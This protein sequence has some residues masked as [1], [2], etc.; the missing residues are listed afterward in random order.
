MSFRHAQRRKG[1]TALVVAG[2]MV[3]TAILAGSLATADSLAYAIR[4]SAFKAL[5][6]ADIFVQ[7]PG[8]LFFPS[9]VYDALRADPNVSGSV[10][11]L[12]PEVLEQT[13]ISLPRTHLHAAAVTVVGFDATADAPFGSFV[14]QNGT[15]TTGAEL[16]PTDVYLD[17]AT[18]STLDAQPGD[19]LRL[20]YGAAPQPVLPEILNFSGTL[21]AAAGPGG[22]SPVPGLP[23]LGPAGYTHSP[24]DKYQFGFATKPDLDFILVVARPLT[25]NPPELDLELRSPSGKDYLNSTGSPSHPILPAILLVNS[26]EQGNWTLLVNSKA[27]TNAPFVATV[28]PFYKIYDLAEFANFTRA[29]G[30]RAQNFSQQFGGENAGGGSFAQVNMTLRGI[31]A[32]TE[33]GNFLLAPLVFMP[34][35]EAQTLFGESQNYNLIKA[36]VDGD[37]ETGVARSD[38]VEGVLTDALRTIAR[39]H[40]GD[41][42]FAHVQ[43]IEVKSRFLNASE[44]AGQNFKE[45]L[46]VVSSFTILAGAM[47]IVNIFIMLVEERRTELGI[48]RA[49]GMLRRHVLALLAAEGA[50]YAIL[51]GLIGLVVGTLLSYGLLT[52][53]NALFL[54]N[55][56][57]FQLVFRP[58]IASFVEAFLGGLLVS[59]GTIV[60]VSWRTSRLN[61]VRAIRRIEDPDRTWR[62][63]S[64]PAGAA[65]AA[66]GLAMS[67]VAFASDVFPLKTIG[68]TFILAGVSLLALRRWPGRVV[69]PYAGAAIAAFLALSFVWFPTPAGI[70]NQIM[71]PI[72]A[73]S[74]VLAATM[75]LVTIPG[76]AALS[77][78]LVGRFRG[79]RAA[80]GPGI[81][82]PHAKRVRSGLTVAI[83]SLVI[84]VIVTFGTLNS[85]FQPDLPAQ[86]GGY[87]VEA[88]TTAPVADLSQFYTQHGVTPPDGQNPLNLIASHDD[89]QEADIFGGAVVRID[90]QTPQ[91]SNGPY[92]YL[93]SYGESFA[94]SNGFTLEERSPQYATD[95][96]AY[97]AVLHDPT[98]AIVARNYLFD[99]NGGIHHVGSRLTLNTTS[100]PANFT[101][102]GIQREEFLGGVFLNPQI[103]STNFHRIYGEYLIRVKP[104]VDPRYAA[105]ELEAGF[106][107]AGMQASSIAD[108]VAKLQQQSE[109]FTSLFQIYLGFGIVVG[110]ASLGIVT[111]RNVVERRQEIGMLRA[112]GFRARDIRNV[113]LLEILYT[114]TL[115][116]LLGIVVGVFL[117]WSVT[118][119][120]SEELG[121]SFAVPWVNLLSILA[122]VYII[123]LAATF[124][125]AWK[126]GKASPSEAV[127]YIE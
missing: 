84:M 19:T 56:T 70:D 102:I 28:L 77:R 112:I 110:V 88:T 2:L 65:V 50:V 74:L 115:G 69:A 118:N 11:G 54:A 38:A 33:K 92:D 46:T 83:F 114:V 41:A 98:L 127:R 113:F 18:A 101:I 106:E 17:Q 44:R 24:E 89:L 117:A 49:V 21:V 68:P 43:S 62:R 27:A 23:S 39:A 5:G 103:L 82:Y 71:G 4:E 64:L 30:P 45:V 40:P 59:M 67:A 99:S 61:I 119:Q 80:A 34:V 124:Y 93:Y 14:L 81:S 20:S 57:R 7:V 35:G 63:V 109:E 120:Y 125:P 3:G 97:E 29:L 91:P 76:V 126:A 94:Q 104:G 87:D 42:A 105:K 32:P 66:I 72:R 9:A 1:Q 116:L 96:A 16:G 73:A 51:A 25:Q 75:L 12:S 15:R 52:E 122:F 58:T 8:Q 95:A 55:E 48:A 123:T 86:Q 78:R 111:A 22:T 47:L 107:N 37:P 31:L 60:A 85:S 10:A 90:N 100:G 79:L 13:T 36:T 26:T 53:F 121:A 6:P 108:E